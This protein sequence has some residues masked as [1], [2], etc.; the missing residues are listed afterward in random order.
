VTNLNL[1]IAVSGTLDTNMPGSYTMTYRTTNALGAV[2]AATRTVVVAD[3]IPPVLKLPGANP[4]MLELGHPFMDPGATAADQCGGDLTG[5]I[6]TTNTVNPNQAGVYTNTFTVTDDSGNAATMN[7]LVLVVTR[8]VLT[9]LEHLGDGAFRFA[10]I[11]TPGAR[12]NVLSTTSLSLP[13]SEWSVLGPVTDSPPGQFQFTDMNATNQPLHF[14][15]FRS[16]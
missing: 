8:P 15:R 10:F 6:L 11:S 7:R 13:T 12:F 5:N 3:R 4:L 9:G 16:P 1:P 2:A 14:Y